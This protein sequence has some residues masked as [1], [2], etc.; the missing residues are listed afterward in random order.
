M[1]DD[2]VD[3]WEY[4]LAL[5]SS[6]FAGQV[7]SKSIMTVISFG[8]HA[9]SFR[10]ERRD[11]WLYFVADELMQWGEAGDRS[12]DADRIYELRFRPAL[13]IPR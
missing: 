5:P 11:Y 2:V 9:G 12:K 13:G 10:S 8:I 7:V 6:D 1:F 4:R 3:V